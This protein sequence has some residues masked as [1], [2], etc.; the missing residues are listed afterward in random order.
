[1]ENL[2]NKNKFIVSFDR[3]NCESKLDNLKI[4]YTEIEES[5]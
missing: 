1:M 3:W 2:M 4:I 5:A